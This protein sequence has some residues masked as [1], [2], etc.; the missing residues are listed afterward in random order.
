MMDK[1]MKTYINRTRASG[2]TI[3]GAV[4][5]DILLIGWGQHMDLYQRLLNY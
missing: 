1:R 2:T 3:L 5:Y 4:D